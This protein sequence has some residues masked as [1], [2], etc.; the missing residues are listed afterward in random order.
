MTNSTTIHFLKTILGDDPSTQAHAW[1][2][3]SGR[4]AGASQ[5]YLFS[6]DNIELWAEYFIELSRTT[7]LWVGLPRLAPSY[8]CVPSK[9]PTTADAVGFPGFFL[10]VDIKNP[11][12]HKSEANPSTEAEARDF[13]QN[14][15]LPPSCIV[16]SGY[17][18]HGHWFVDHLTFADE[19]ERLRAGGEL[20]RIFSEISYL[21]M[22]KH[23][24]KLDNV[25]DLAR[26]TRLPG[27]WNIKDP[28]NPRLVTA[29][30]TDGPRYP[31]LEAL[32]FATIPTGNGTAVTARIARGAPSR[33]PPNQ[34]ASTRALLSKLNAA[35]AKA[36]AESKKTGVSPG[37]NFAAIAAGCPF[38]AESLVHAAT[39]TEPEWFAQTQISS[40]CYMGPA[41]SHQISEPY[42]GY[43]KAETQRLVDRAK[44]Y[45]PTC[46]NI[47]GVAPL[48]CQGCHFLGQIKSPLQFGSSSRPLV[49]LAC[50]W[51]FN[52]QDNRW[53]NLTRPDEELTSQAFS[54]LTSGKVKKATNLLP[55]QPFFRFISRRDYV[56][57]NR[58]MIPDSDRWVFNSYRDPGLDET[59]DQE[60]ERVFLEHLQFV[61]NYDDDQTNQ[62]LTYI[63]AAF[64]TPEKIAHA[65]LIQSGQGIGKSLLMKALELA[66]GSSNFCTDNFQRVNA[67]FNGHIHDKQLLVIEELQSDK[68]EAYNEIKTLIT[69]PFGKSEPKGLKVRDVRNPTGIIILTN[70]DVPILIEQGD[71]RFYVIQGPGEPREQSKYDEFHDVV[72]SNPGAL[73]GFLM[74]VDTSHFNRKARPPMTEAKRSLLAGSVGAAEMLIQEAIEVRRG[75]GQFDVTL[76]ADW[77]TYLQNNG[78]GLTVQQVAKL[79]A[80]AGMVSVQIRDPRALGDGRDAKVR[81]WIVRNPDELSGNT[82]E[83]QR[84]FLLSAQVGAALPRVEHTA[85]AT[86][87]ARFQMTQQQ[88]ALSH[89]PTVPDDFLSKEK[90]PPQQQQP[91]SSDVGQ[92][93]NDPT[94]GAK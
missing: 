69:E 70:E 15:P 32:K 77:R 85:I 18:L 21:A 59:P 13:L 81:V 26:L 44:E 20:K 47:Q 39:L 89:C 50:E 37:P 5:T 94:G 64:Q 25:A 6:S 63:A 45:T 3:E 92:W 74:S 75:P 68:R 35:W 42:P 93:D 4:G 51:A 61:A 78:K 58:Q 80:A 66:L 72:L 49:E 29:L 24:W 38:I 71:R 27:T 40:K 48:T 30:K 67:R 11:L 46:R 83:I 52:P 14:L 28:D 22:T 12:A 55:K 54:T 10:D 31:G 88:G 7:P 19:S 73:R 23:G 17:G 90:S 56:P 57:G 79:L 76:A 2:K 60:V 91:T 53:L 62:L 16:H 41:I 1:T 9:R 33:R 36:K 82:K 84:R 43:D 86:L 8:T 34:P 87:R 65:I